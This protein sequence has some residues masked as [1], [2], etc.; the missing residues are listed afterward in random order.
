[1]GGIWVANINQFSLYILF[2]NSPERIYLQCIKGKIKC[3]SINLLI[4]SM[5]VTPLRNTMILLKILQD[6]LSTFID[7]Q[8]ITK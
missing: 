4:W 6:S 2:F 1:M 3:F 8:L 5:L 7:N